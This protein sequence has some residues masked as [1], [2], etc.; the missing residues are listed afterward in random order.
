MWQ[1]NDMG[2]KLHT[3]GKPSGGRNLI[4]STLRTPHLGKTKDQRLTTM[5][6][7]LEHNCLELPTKHLQTTAMFFFSGHEPR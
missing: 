5:S 1:S 7:C 3:C 2:S 4:S 6:N